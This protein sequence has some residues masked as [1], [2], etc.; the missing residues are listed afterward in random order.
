VTR[1]V[2]DS[3][4]INFT[5]VG[6]HDSYID[7]FLD[8]VDDVL[9]LGHEVFF[10]D[11]L[12]NRPLVGEKTLWE[13]F[14][15]DSPVFL[16]TGLRQRLAALFGAMPRWDT[17][18]LPW[19]ESFDVVLDGSE[20]FESPSIAW[21]HKQSTD[22]GLNSPA[23]LCAAGTRTTGMVDVTVDGFTRPVWMIAQLEHI[24]GF[25]RWLIGSYSTHTDHFEEYCK[26]AFK[27]V[28]FTS[29]CFDGIS[30]MSKPLRQ[31]APNI[32]RHLGSISDHGARI[33]LGPRQRVQAEFGALGIEVTDENGNTKSKVTA[34]KERKVTVDGEEHYFW[35]HCKLEPDRDRIHFCPDRIAESGQIMVGIFCRHL[36]T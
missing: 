27:N 32:V 1:F 14:G 11:E 28:Y 31:I 2:V 8:L 20:A 33:F 22:A 34:A 13:L 21:T 25:F 19:P 30:G 18:D 10:D 6:D 29:K 26:S 23:C 4:S 16:T 17:L 12:F 35:W 24:E 36:T 9:E 15:D 3:G 5:G 7:S